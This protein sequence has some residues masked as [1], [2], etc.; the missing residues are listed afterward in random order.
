[1][2]TIG[3]KYRKPRELLFVRQKGERFVYGIAF[4]ILAL[5]AILM[6]APM[7]M[8]LLSSFKNSL[9]YNEELFNGT[10]Y[11]FPAKLQLSN[12][13]KAFSLMKV[14]IGLR[15]VMLPEMIWNTLWMA[16]GSSVCVVFAQLATGYVCAR[17]ES[18]FTR[19]M[20]IVALAMLVIPIYGSTGMF[21]KTIQF[22]GLYDNWLL[23]FVTA[24]QGFGFSLFI[25]K[26]FFKG[27]SWNYAEAV[28]IDGGGHFTVFFKIM[29]PQAIPLAIV[30]FINNF[31][32][33]YSDYMTKILYMPSFVTIAVG[34]YY[35]SMLLPR[36]GET[37]I[38]FAAL[39]M[40]CVPIALIYIFLG[41]RMMTSM[42]IGGLKG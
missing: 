27:V 39:F 41:K 17:Y 11:N 22:L 14:P 34:L 40:S 13:T 30:F 23:V 19:G 24:F 12:Y 38:Y 33:Q 25:I 21:M 42:N 4:I 6:L 31:L 18:F 37:P 5:Y 8:I 10:I 28:F 16:I 32:A 1:M 20:E 26:S 3:K 9:V 2:K 29:L 7:I 36:I 35:E 15:E